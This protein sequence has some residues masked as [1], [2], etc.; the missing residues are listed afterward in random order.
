MHMYVGYRLPVYN[1]SGVLIDNYHSTSI[2]CLFNGES[3]GMV[4]NSF[5]FLWG[6]EISEIYNRCSLHAGKENTSSRFL[7]LVGR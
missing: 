3:S 1:E 7:L 4:S 6:H 2:H 5:Y